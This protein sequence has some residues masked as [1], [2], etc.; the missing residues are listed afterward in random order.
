MEKNDGIGSLKQETDYVFMRYYTL[1]PGAN[2]LSRVVLNEVLIIGA[3][4]RTLTSVVESG[5]NGI[6]GGDSYGCFGS[7]KMTS[8][9]HRNLVPR[10]NVPRIGRVSPEPVVHDAIVTNGTVLKPLQ[11]RRQS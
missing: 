3:I 1:N 7:G 11:R 10:G 9:S 6:R 2:N 4:D 8:R 5:C